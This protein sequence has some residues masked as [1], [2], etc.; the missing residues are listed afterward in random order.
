MKKL[1]FF[2]LHQIEQTVSI[3]VVPIGGISIDTLPLLKG[4]KIEGVES[5]F[6]DNGSEDAKEMVEELKQI[7]NQKN[8]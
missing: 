1:C 8:P 5:C 6:G 4:L 7:I 2:P 3:L